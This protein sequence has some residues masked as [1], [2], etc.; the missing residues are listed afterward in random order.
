LL[1]PRKRIEKVI[2]EWFRSMGQRP[3]VSA[4]D[5]AMGWVADDMV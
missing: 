2:A 1:R 5:E 3:G 4:S